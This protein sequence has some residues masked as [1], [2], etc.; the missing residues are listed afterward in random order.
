MDRLFKISYDQKTWNIKGNRTEGYR[1]IKK[2]NCELYFLI[3]DIIGIEQINSDSFLI[4]CKVSNKEWIIKRFKLYNG[5]KI[6]KYSHRFRTF[7]FLSENLIVFDKDSISSCKLYNIQ[8]NIEIPH[9]DFISSCKH[10]IDFC[11][12]RHIKFL[13]NKSFCDYPKYLR[14]DYSL[15]S[16]YYTA[17]LQFIIDAKSFKILSPAYSTLRR[18]YIEITSADSVLKLFEETITSLKILDS[19]LHPHFEK[20]L[21]KKDFELWSCL[22]KNN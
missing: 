21:R 1:F 19:S 5:L 8:E 11:H 10:D 17:Y 4:Y 14:I 3:G 2:S 15:R 6:E 9:L 18:Q 16:N 7:D 13:Y 22:D 20:D 12:E